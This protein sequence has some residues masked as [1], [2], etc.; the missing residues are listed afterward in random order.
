MKRFFT[1]FLP[2]GV[3]LGGLVMGLILVGGSVLILNWIHPGAQLGPVNT[4]QMVVLAAPTYT[5][6]LPT[7]EPTLE[8][9]ATS[10]AAPTPPPVDVQIGQMVQ[11]SGTGV[12]GLRLRV[13]PGLQGK[14]M[15]VAIEAEVF[16]VLDG[17][18]QADGY[19]WWYLVSPIQA[20]YKGWA[21]ANYL[22]LMQQSP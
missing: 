17:P 10:P 18:R 3:L 14:I 9:T 1:E 4:A 22:A 16:Q 5:P 6:P 21:V 7:V 11:I 20:D 12:D 13:E 15:F 2:P 8:P 19:I